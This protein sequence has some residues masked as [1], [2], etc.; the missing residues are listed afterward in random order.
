MP[1]SKALEKSA[2][3]FSAKYV[4]T[5]D[6]DAFESKVEEFTF[7]RPNNGWISVYKI[8]FDGVYKNA[9]E[10]AAMGKNNELD[11][12]AM[13]DDFEYTLIRPFVNETQIE[14]KHKPYAGMDRITRL[15]YLD[16]LAKQAPFNLVS[17]YT[18]K[19]KSG[20]LSIKQMNRQLKLASI[21]EHT[22][23]ARYIKIAG[24]IQAL[25]NANESRSLMWRIFHPFRNRAE[26]RVA[27]IMKKSLIEKM[28]GGEEFYEEIAAATHETFDGHKRA[29][30]RLQNSIAHAR[31]EIRRLQKMNE[32]MRE[33]HRIEGFAK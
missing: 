20:K 1:V 18:E 28:Q 3:E 21:P 10:S 24:Y 16:R 29:N 6:F 32:A 9:L 19:Y 23:R 22:E 2:K 8:V 25:E 12:E 31:E 11:G 5:F 27:V 15:D 14:I 30:A 17:L 4:C 26:K 13:L 7:L 33:S